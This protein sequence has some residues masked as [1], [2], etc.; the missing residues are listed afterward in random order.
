LRLA[1]ATRDRLER[2][3]EA[4]EDTSFDHA[5]VVSTF[6]KLVMQTFYAAHGDEKTMRWFLLAEEVERVARAA[7]P[8]QA[9]TDMARARRV[10]ER[11]GSLFPELAARLDQRAVA[12]AVTAWRKQNKRFEMI[13]AALAPIAGQ[14]PKLPTASSMRQTWSRLTKNVPRTSTRRRTRRS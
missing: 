11:Y 4:L 13:H 1:H 14:S 7:S 5:D 6:E 9:V 10:I 8:E 2:A 12:K 3:I